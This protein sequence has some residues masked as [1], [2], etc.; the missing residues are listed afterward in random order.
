MVRIGET[1][2]SSV[3]VL[4]G[5]I[6]LDR[7]YVHGHPTLSLKRC[8]ALNGVS[9]AVIDSYLSECHAI[10]QDSQAIGGWAGP[11]P[12]KIVNNYLE[13]A[14]ENILFGGAPMRFGVGPADIEI[15]G[16]YLYKPLSW[17]ASN[18]WVVKNLFELKN[19]QRVLFENNV[20]ENNWAG[21]QTGYAILLQSLNDGAGAT[22]VPATVR[23]VTIRYNRVAVSTAGMNVL[24]GVRYAGDGPFLPASRILV[25]HNSFEEIARAD[26]PGTG[27]LM[28]IMG[29]LSDFMIRHNTMIFARQT[30]AAIMLDSP[31][32]DR[33]HILDNV[34]SGGDYGLF[35]SGV[36]EGTKA[37]N[38]ILTNWVVTANI[39]SG[40]PASAYPSGNFFPS[41]IPASPPIGTDGTPIGVNT[42]VL[43]QRLAGVVP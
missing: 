26:V 40:R 31:W 30:G 43:Q 42:L 18:T 1:N 29:G 28:Q 11:G 37:L 5:D 35:G 12:F 20:L 15:R 8:V 2:E 32:G 34:F 13:G 24:A 3:G 4:P 7:I 19:A 14:G 22:T 36:G 10:G 16:N 38:A 17:K 9:T 6:V 41:S 21:G 23:D 39:F 33:V 25:E 27:R